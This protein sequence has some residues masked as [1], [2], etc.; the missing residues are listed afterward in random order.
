MDSAVERAANRLGITPIQVIL[1]WV[2]A[3]FAKELS[4]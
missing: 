2:K 1:L 3:K 4:L